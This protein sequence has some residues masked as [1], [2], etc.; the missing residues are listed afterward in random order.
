MSLYHQVYNGESFS[1]QDFYGAVRYVLGP[2]SY[3]YNQ[4]QLENAI[5][6]RVDVLGESDAENF[7]RNLGKVARNVG[8]GALKVVSVAA[9]V[10]GNIIGGPIGGAIGKLGGN[11]AGAAASAIQ[12]NPQGRQQLQQAWQQTRQMGQGLVQQVAPVVQQYVADNPVAVNQ[13]A[14]Q[15]AAGMQ[16]L[17]SQLMGL[18]NN[19]QLQAALAQ[20]SVGAVPA[21]RPTESHSFTEMVESLYSLSGDLLKEYYEGGLID[22]ESY[23]YDRYGQLVPLDNYRVARLTE[24]IAY[25]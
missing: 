3:H 5:L 6:D 19:P 17:L 9:P 12:G 23:A 18:M 11:L 1:E 21:N 20:Q 7:W 14:A 24:S 15:N 10:A 2:E 13:P 8:T 16:D 22:T 25:F 4:E